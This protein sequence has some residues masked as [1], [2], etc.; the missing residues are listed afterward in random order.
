M[1]SV[2]GLNAN[3]IAKELQGY[4]RYSEKT[5]KEIK[6]KL[7]NVTSLRDELRRLEKEHIKNDINNAK[8]N[9]N[10]DVK[11]IKIYL[12]GVSYTEEDLI[13]MV[14][15]YHE[16]VIKPSQIPELNT[17]MYKEILLRAT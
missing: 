7:G 14:K 2:S 4:K 13:K 9:T 8:I 12:E 15:Y 10:N 6:N 17:D 1:D 3:Q 16:H 11:N 5:Q